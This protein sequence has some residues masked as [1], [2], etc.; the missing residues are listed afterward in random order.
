[1]QV[2]TGKCSIV[3]DMWKI[4]DLSIFKKF[5]ETYNFTAHYGVFDLKQFAKDGITDIDID[6][7][8]LMFTQLIHAKHSTD[9]GIRFGLAYLV[10]GFFGI[11]VSKANQAH[12]WE[13]P[14]LTYEQVEY[15]A[16]DAIYVRKL[17]EVM[18]PVLKSK[19]LY[20]YYL[21]CKEMQHVVTEVELLGIKL[22]RKKHI[23]H[24]DK[25]RDDL[26]KAKKKLVK[27]T[28][29]RKITSHTISN[30]LKKNLDKEY[31]EIW[32][33]TDTGLL[34]T[35]FQT[36]SDFEGLPIVAPLY[37][38]KK[39]SKMTTSWYKYIAVYKPRD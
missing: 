1:M 11:K 6:C 9:A 16:L 34:K 13:I 7:T 2:Y 8:M 24:V 27:M 15:A 3:F 20:K 14:V 28:G 4:S 31:L 5:L 38:F 23:S 17:H 37:T 22:S 36:F 12:N 19:K 32:P 39:L 26:Y 30:Y 21:L 10:E 29:L 35:D 25:W 33:R 18:L